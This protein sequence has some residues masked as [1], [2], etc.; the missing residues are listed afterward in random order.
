MTITWKTEVR[1]L[2]EL[3][4]YE[5]NPRTIT[6]DDLEKLKKSITESGYHAP[7]LI[8]TDNTIIAGHARWHAMKQL[9]VKTVDC[10]VPDR[11]LTE[12]EFKSINIRDNVNNGNWDVDVLANNFNVADLIEWGV[13]ENLFE[14]FN[15][16][17]FSP[18]PESA[19]DRLD[20]K[21]LTE[22]P[23]CGHEF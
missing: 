16:P 18:Q 1:R 5:F 2:T 3:K 20:E 15:T 22:C 6:K 13:P 19:D 17:D 23:E 14:G 10:R 11:K 21:T 4:P 7:I 8:D 9:K 12:H